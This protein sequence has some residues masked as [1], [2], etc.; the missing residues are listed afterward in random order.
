MPNLIRSASLTHF[1]EI[2]QRGRLD[3]YALVRAAAL[4]TRCL[5]DPDLRV[6]AHAVMRLL[7]R[8]A[9]E[10]DDPA[11]GLRMGESRRLSNLGPLGLLLR[12]EPTLRHALDAIVRHIRLHN[13]A[14][15][16]SIQEADDLVII[17]EEFALDSL[18]PQRQA[19]ELAMAVT[20]RMLRLFMGGSWQPRLIGFAHSAPRDLSTHR[21]IFGDRVQFNQ[22]F[23]GLL[24]RRE[25]LNQPNPTADPV[26]ARYAQEL[27]AA[28]PVDTPSFTQQVQQMI[29]L[30]LPL[31]QCGAKVV[32][33]HMGCD[34]RTI[35]RRL[36]LENTGFHEL[37]NDHR[38]R[39]ASKYLLDR[40]KPLSQVASLLG[41]SA[42][43]AFSRWYREQ[44]GELAKNSYPKKKQTFR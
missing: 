2:A 43:S 13:E 31:G 22:E 21:R 23:N 1:A 28:M 30:L 26:M 42:P 11:F 41:F 25:D 20:Y 38:R 19:V 8:A 14:L 36:S 17:R 24:C 7:E 18:Q 10:A 5:S 40:S 6:D 34:R 32:A 27:I 4:P 33:Q 29:L 39:M 37:V 3:P 9:N 12:D 44:F 35:T 15:V 16:V